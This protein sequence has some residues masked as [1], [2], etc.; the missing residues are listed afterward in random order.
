MLRETIRPLLDP[1]LGHNHSTAADTTT[2]QGECCVGATPVHQRYT[3]F[4]HDQ[5][6][7]DH[8]QFAVVAAQVTQCFK[9]AHRLWVLLSCSFACLQVCHTVETRECPLS[10]SSC[11]YTTAGRL[12]EVKHVG[13]LYVC[14][15]CMLCAHRCSRIST[16]SKYASA[17]RAVRVQTAATWQ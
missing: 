6:L 16:K 5:V 9:V 8:V 15:L 12:D 13:L 1:E 7:L 10:F 4:C 17:N 3:C 11:S 14:P 2:E